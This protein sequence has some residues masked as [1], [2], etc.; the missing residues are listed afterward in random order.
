MRLAACFLAVGSA[1]IFV[2]L[3]PEAN[4]LWAANGI[5][6]AYLLVAPHR[7]WPAY[8]LAGFAAQWLG[9]ALIDA[10]SIVA[11]TTLSA[12]VLALLNMA[13]VLLAAGLL[14]RRARDLPRFT[15][16]AYLLRFVSCA[17]V[18]AP[19]LTGFGYLSAMWILHHSSPGHLLMRWALTDGLGAAVTTP[20]YVALFQVK[21][22]HSRSWRRN[23]IWLALPVAASTIVFAQ[24]S[25]PLIFLVYP[26]LLL[27]VLRLGLGWASLA[28]LLV[29]GAGSWFTIH[30]EG[31][32]AAF[33]P[34]TPLDPTVL[35]QIFIAGAMFM[36]YCVAVAVDSRKLAELRLEEM[37]KAWRAAEALAV[38]DPVTGLANRRQFDQCLAGE[39]R[40]ALRDGKPLSL[41]LMDADLFK[42]YNDS[43]GHI[44]G[45]A[46]L[47][48][49]AA[50][51]AEVVS[52]PGDLVARF[53]GE[54]F[55]AILP[56]TSAAGAEEIAH[57][58]CDALRRRDLSHAAN[59]CGKVTVSVGCA[60]LVPALGQSPLLLLDIA[61]G[62][63][64]AA[65]VGG[66]N[67]VCSA[68]GGS[69]ARVID[70]A[71]LR[72]AQQ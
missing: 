51:A 45:D 36:L 70:I 53:G 23:W 63:L 2:G 1:T 18:A 66:R 37:R 62:A 32:F 47:Q 26:V 8:V 17:V 21:P 61:D 15:D 20:A 31:A 33:R 22:N 4:L 19:L 39:W 38:V 43:Y 3:A 14:R 41:L 28:T 7:R 50:A 27:V 69:K 13:E 6:L 16:G 52:R 30:G 56:D 34:I 71:E 58:I 10:Q 46:C 68:S 67:R 55:A 35:L 44:N 5:L 48:Q 57:A 59:P 40:R 29:A 49:I 64:Y 24:A 65:K 25:A 60:T 12:F 72:A 54:E 42:S 11:Q 9:I